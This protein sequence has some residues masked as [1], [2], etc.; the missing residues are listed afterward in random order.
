LKARLQDVQQ[1]ADLRDRESLAPQIRQDHQ[2]EQLDRRVTAFGE[3][4]R[5]GLV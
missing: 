4:A 1:L 2:L 3:T 5:L